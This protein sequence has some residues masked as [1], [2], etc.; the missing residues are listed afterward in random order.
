MRSFSSLGECCAVFVAD[1][2]GSEFMHEAVMMLKGVLGFDD[3]PLTAPPKLRRIRTI[4]RSYSE[5]RLRRPQVAPSRGSPRKPPPQQEEL[6]A[7]AE[8]PPPDP[9]RTRAISDPF[10]D[11][12]TGQRRPSGRGPAPP[13]PPSRS[14]HRSAASQPVYAAEPTSHAESPLL[15]RDDPIGNPLARR[16]S[17]DRELLLGNGRTMSDDSTGPSGLFANGH[18]VMDNAIVEDDE[19][20]PTEDDIAAEESELNQPRFRLWVFPAHI[21][22][23]EAENLLGLFP[24]FIRGGRGDVRFPFMRPGRGVKDLESGT[25]PGWDTIVLESQVVAKV[26]KLDLESEEGVIRHGTGR[27]WVGL[28]TRTGGWAGGT[29]YRFRR[30]W[31]RL[32][33]MG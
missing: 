15:P 6:L 2:S 7:N 25:E 11:A 26:P 8:A 12:R 30:W 10:T 3:Q 17:E 4:P 18:H 31:R 13:P 33:G 16:M 5:A 14:L 1:P 28:E 21:A 20:D 32:F 27:M 22:D 23:P 24:A 29:W 9:S 19:D